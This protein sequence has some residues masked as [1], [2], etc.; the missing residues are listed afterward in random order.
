MPNLLIFDCDGTLVDSEYLYNSITARLLNTLGFEE[1]TPE[2]CLELFAGHSWK[3]IQTM[4]KEKHG[5]NIPRNIVDLYI[6]EA[7]Q[8]MTT[9]LK[10][11]AQASHVLEK[12]QKTRK[13]C[14]ASNGE[15]GNV[16]KSLRLTNLLPYFDENTQ[17]FTKIQVKHPKPAPDLF[18]FAAQEM[19]TPP[20]KCL[21]IEDSI[22]GV[23]AAKAANMNVIGFI[24]TAHTPEKAAQNLK[25]AGADHICDR[26]IHILNIAN[27]S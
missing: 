21:V 22:T 19:K 10:P 1:Y 7:N 23:L 3:T 14:V 12:A 17:I 25:N 8:A 2:L 27:I 18:L 9:N 16:L 11:S 20:S 13:I 15:R 24:G 5:R 4:L 26:L 6:K